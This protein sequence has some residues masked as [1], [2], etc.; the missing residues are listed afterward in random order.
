M[1]S[2]SE[3]KYERLLRW[4]PR[5]WR[6][7][8]G[9][10]VLTTLLE[11][12]DARGK[13]GPTPTEAWSLRVDGLRNRWRGPAAGRKGRDEHMITDRP[14]W[15]RRAS[16]ISAASLL[17]L[18]V[19]GWVLGRSQDGLAAGAAGE[20]TLNALLQEASTYER[21]I[22]GD[23]VVTAAEYEQALLDW[24][25]CVRAAG[26]EPSEIYAIG[27]NQLTFDYD[28]TAATNEARIELEAEAETCLPEY[29]DEVASWWVEQDTQPSPTAPL[30]SQ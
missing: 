28:I 20:R 6:D 11:V 16:A 25:D 1:T 3:R 21:E 15:I 18:A 7:L 30:A 13:A 22:L 10:F 19:G 14:A 12:D 24:R 9:R 4:Y 5:W 8:H 23:G 26:A 27:D 2:P 17:T 29:F